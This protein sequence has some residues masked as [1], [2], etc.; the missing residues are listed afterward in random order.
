MELAGPHAEGN[1]KAPKD[2]VDSA[3]RAP[4]TGF[5]QVEEFVVSQDV[6]KD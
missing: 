5:H 4:V 1:T 2:L 3:V 6:V